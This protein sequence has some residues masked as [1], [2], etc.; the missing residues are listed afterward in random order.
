[1]VIVG[2]VVIVGI[3]FPASCFSILSMEDRI[4]ATCAAKELT[5]F[6]KDLIPSKISG[7]ALALHVWET[8]V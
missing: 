8:T 5:V 1:M 3:D 6:V 4:E 7:E 2:A